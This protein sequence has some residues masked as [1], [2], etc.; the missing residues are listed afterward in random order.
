MEEEFRY[1]GR[2]AT[3]VEVEFIRKMMARYPQAN[4]RQRRAR[5]ETDAA[6]A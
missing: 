6:R 4:R 3:A 5:S 1:R 2:V